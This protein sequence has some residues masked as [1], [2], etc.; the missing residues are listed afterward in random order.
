[1]DFKLL[2]NIVLKNKTSLSYRN[3]EKLFQDK[4]VKNIDI[5]KIGKNT[6]IYGIVQ[7][8][9]RLISTNIKL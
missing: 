2:N 9:V 3:G 6:I 4:C 1:M 8:K 7:D 5:R